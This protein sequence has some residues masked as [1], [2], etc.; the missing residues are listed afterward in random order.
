MGKLVND[1]IDVVTFG[2]VDDALGL[3]GADKATERAGQL[4]ADAANQAIAEQRRQFDETQG[5][6]APF[7][8][9]GANALQ[10]QQDLLSGKTKFQD[11]PGQRF[12]RERAERSLLRNQS[13]I[14]GLGGGNVRSA[15]QQQ[16]IGLAAQDFGNQ[17]SRLGQ[18]AGQ[19]QSAA[20]NIGQFGQ[21]T[22]GNIGQFGQRASEARASGILGQQQNRAALTSQLLSLG[23]QVGGAALGAG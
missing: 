17:F 19:G 2:A 3:K 9:A 4:Q 7:R 21:A 12:L 1:A 14:G 23:G 20:T 22:A 6:L 15:L 16:A 11:T 13:A 10:Q 8:E 18:I 5:S